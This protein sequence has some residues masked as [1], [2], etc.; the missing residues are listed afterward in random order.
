MGGWK[1]KI[2]GGAEEELPYVEMTR[3]LVNDFP[4]G[5]GTYDVEPDASGASFFWGAHWLLR[6]RGSHITV[7]TAASSG[8]QADQKFHDLIVQQEWRSA[9]SRRTDLAD[10]IMT[11]IVLAPFAPTST[12]FTDLGRLRVQESERVRA[13]HK[14]NCRSV[15]HAWTRPVTPL[16][17][18]RAC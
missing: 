11:A 16:E 18:I 8:M 4:W 7:M 2:T 15:A 13:L 1:V 10:S 3:R 9:Y 14:R 17:S 12:L 6:D 5:G